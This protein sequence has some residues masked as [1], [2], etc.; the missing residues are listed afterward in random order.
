MPIIATPHLTREHAI[1]L[2]RVANVTLSSA[3]HDF[4]DK[5]LEIA[6]QALENIHL[7]FGATVGRHAGTVTSD[8]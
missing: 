1:A 8:L 6:R 4:S 2:L 5:E 7:A 3:R